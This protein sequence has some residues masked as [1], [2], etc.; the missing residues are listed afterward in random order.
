MRNWRRPATLLALYAA[1]L[2]GSWTSFLVSCATVTTEMTDFYTL[3]V[4][5]W[6]CL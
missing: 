4:S 5:T 1:T 2:H 6:F 3:A